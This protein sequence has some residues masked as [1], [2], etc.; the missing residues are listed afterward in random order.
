MTERP[1]LFSAPMVNAILEGRKT[2]TR[3]MMEVQPPDWY[4]GYVD[5]ASNDAFAVWLGETEKDDATQGGELKFP[6]GNE[7]D[8]LWVRENFRFG[9]GYDNVKPSAVPKEPFVK[10]WYEADGDTPPHGF[11]KQRP[12]IFLPRYF[13]RL[14]LRITDI[15]VERL[16]S[17]SEEDAQAEGA[18]YHNGGAIGNSGWRHD[19]KDVHPTARQSFGRLWCEI[20]GRESWDSNPFVWV[21]GF[22]RVRT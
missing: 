7:G 14:T 15:R 8:T 20:N 12:S 9:T 10:I 5:K 2:Q 21:I 17:I 16:Q 22:E 4:D 1:I 18:A 19:L 6:Y 13:S 11:G 3:R